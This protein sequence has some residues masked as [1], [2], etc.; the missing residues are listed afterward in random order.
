M[1]ADSGAVG[2]LSSMLWS[3]GSAR[4]R[5]WALFVAVGSGSVVAGLLSGTEPSAAQTQAQAKELS[6][7]QIVAFRFPSAWNSARPAQAPAVTTVPKHNLFD[8]NP[9][10]ALASAESRPAVLPRGLL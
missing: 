6:P 10:Y 8:P 1:A 3:A 4:E 5:A 2:G 7:A 9:T